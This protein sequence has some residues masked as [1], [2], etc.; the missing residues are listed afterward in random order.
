MA[1]A[2]GVK[3][4]AE[5]DLTDWEPDTNPEGRNIEAEDVEN[6]RQLF[7]IATA[8]AV[9]ATLAAIILRGAITS[10]RR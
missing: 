1:G 4:D 5:P 7:W 9:A 8:W 10:R 2:L 6:A 3:L